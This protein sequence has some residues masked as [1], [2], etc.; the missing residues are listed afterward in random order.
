MNKR[1]AALVAATTALAVFPALAGAHPE[2]P[3]ELYIPFTAEVGQ[4][5]AQELTQGGAQLEAAEQQA[6]MSDTENL[7]LV[8]NVD[9]DETTNSDLA[10]NGNL[11]YAGNYD[12]F[13][14]LDIRGSQPRV[15]V[16]HRCRGPQNDVSFHE[17]GG[18]TFL[19]QSVDTA[20]TSED[21]TSR[22]VPV[23]PGTPRVG[24]EGIRVFDVSNPAQPVFLD[25]IQTSCGSH[26]HSLLPAESRRG[27]GKAYIYVASYPLG[28]NITP[29]NPPDPPGGDDFKPCVNPHAKISIIEVS[30]PRGEFQFRLRE[31]PLAPDTV[32]YAGGI[33]GTTP[34][35]ACHDVQF[36]MKRDIAL[37]SCAGE[38]QI[39]DV[40]NPWMPGIER[41]E[42]HT[43]IRKPAGSTPREFEF[44]H[45]AVFTWDGKYLAT[46]DETGGGVEAR[47]NATSPDGYYYFYRAVEPG[48]PEPPLL[49]RYKIPRDQGTQECVSHNA[50]VIPVDDKYLAS[51]AYYQGGVTVVDF[52]DVRNPREVAYADVSDGVGTSDEW[53]SYWYNGRIYSNSGLNREGPLANRGVDVWRPTGR[54][55]R[56]VRGAERWEYSNPQTQEGWQAPDGD[57]DDDSDDD[58]DSDD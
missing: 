29:P 53:S 24:Y 7:E 34:F 39:W 10:F 1:L 54:L 58:S 11:A 2:E 14:I 22:D 46:M 47:C 12:G 8:G 50:T 51:A 6:P 31:Q 40:S 43:H 57:S 48:S 9:K 13:R 35:V 44:M 38:S 18:K 28:S 27:G 5:R 25:M 52:T 36:L 21:C 30:A 49:S 23:P 15:V 33:P 37:G 19:F 17:M 3:G 45:S 20:Q 55:A 41:E 4:E 16:D 42:N 26:T 32:P 56:A